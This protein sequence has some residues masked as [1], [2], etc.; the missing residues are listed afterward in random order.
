MAIHFPRKVPASANWSDYPHVITFVPLK[1][2]GIEAWWLPLVYEPVPC[3][4]L[5]TR[6]PMYPIL[7]PPDFQ[8]LSLA[9]MNNL[10]QP[11]PPKKNSPFVFITIVNRSVGIPM[12]NSGVWLAWIYTKWEA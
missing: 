7:E 10:S 3:A 12:R 11:P 5:S 2:F 6:D 9:L 4:P 8:E 1:R